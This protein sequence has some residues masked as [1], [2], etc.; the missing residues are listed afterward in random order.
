MNRTIGLRRSLWA[1]VAFAEVGAF[2]AFF[3]GDKQPIINEVS[4]GKPIMLGIELMILAGVSTYVVL[5]KEMRKGLIRLII[6]VETLLLIFLATRLTDTAVSAL[7]KE[8][9]AMDMLVLALLIA[10]QLTGLREQNRSAQLN[11]PSAV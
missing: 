6:G 7:T 5:Q 11:H 4:A 8:L 1:T 9:V 3:L 10:F 2:L